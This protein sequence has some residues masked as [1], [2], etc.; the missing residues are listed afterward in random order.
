MGGRRVPRVPTADAEGPEHPS[1]GRALAPAAGRTGEAGLTLVEV[2][3]SIALMS[4]VVVGFLGSLGSIVRISH[5]DRKGATVEAALRTG[6]AALSRLDYE[7]CTEGAYPEAELSDALAQAIPPG[8]EAEV[9]SVLFSD[10]ANPP[11]FTET[12]PA[13]DQGLQQL[14]LRVWSDDGHVSARLPVT[15]R[16]P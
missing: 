2:I 14:V 6:A 1:G 16:K 13:Q 3:I 9:V 12:C 11:S 7:P 10:G 5:V 4:V 15:K 8:Y